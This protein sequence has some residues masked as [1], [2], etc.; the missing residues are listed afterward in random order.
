MSAVAISLLYSPICDYL[1]LSVIVLHAAVTEAL[2]AKIQALKV[3]KLNAV[4]M[5]SKKNKCP[6]C[7]N[8]TPTKQNTNN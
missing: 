6:G 3:V 4:Q 7:S 1:N 5:R 2:Q 8:F